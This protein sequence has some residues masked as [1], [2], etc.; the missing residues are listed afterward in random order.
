MKLQAGTV[1]GARTRGKFWLYSGGRGQ[2]VAPFIYLKH[3]QSEKE[4]SSED[5]EAQAPQAA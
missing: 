5:V 3:G 2:H 1:T 4:A